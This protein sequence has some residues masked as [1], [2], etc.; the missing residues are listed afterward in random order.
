MIRKDI[1]IVEYRKATHSAKALWV[2]SLYQK[3]S[4]YIAYFSGSLG[5]SPNHL[6]SLSLLL[7]VLGLA[8]LVT[9]ELSLIVVIVVF[10]IMAVAYLLDCADGQ[11]AR[12]TEQSSKFGAW[13]DHV[14]D[15]TKIFLTHGAIGWLLLTS[16]K[17]AGEIHWCYLAVLLNMSGTALYFFSWN[18]KVMLVGE[19][20][21]AKQSAE[22]EKVRVSNYRLLLQLTDYGLFLFLI[23]LLIDI[24]IFKDAYMA[25]GCFSWGVFACYIAMSGYYMRKLNT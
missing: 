3:L 10:G 20:F 22:G 2:T 9:V 8:L 17:I 13:Y 1:P 21:I 15:A 23:L 16:T 19:E 24:E 4:I 5:L 25:Y 6:T 12:V 7:V 14:S 11:L 18:Y